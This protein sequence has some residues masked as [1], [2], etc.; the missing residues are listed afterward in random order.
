METLQLAQGCMYRPFCTLVRYLE[1]VESVATY[2][3]SRQEY[4]FEWLHI[5]QKHK[6]KY[7][8]WQGVCIF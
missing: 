1:K 6:S 4:E 2:T 8:T 5:V 7:L 3:N